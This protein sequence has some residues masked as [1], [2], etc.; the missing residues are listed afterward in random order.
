MDKR[1]LQREIKGREGNWEACMEKITAGFSNHKEW[2]G[3]WV[4]RGELKTTELQAM[5]QGTNSATKQAEMDVNNGLFIRGFVPCYPANYCLEV[6][7]TLHT[8]A[9]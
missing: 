1:F 2:Q 7:N 3:G 9:H 5:F 6:L 8:C 4:R